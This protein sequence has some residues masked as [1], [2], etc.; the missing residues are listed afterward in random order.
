VKQSPPATIDTAIREVISRYPQVKLA[1][2]F[3]SSAKGTDTA[4]SDLDIAVLT[5]GPLASDLKIQI[6]GD[7][8][9]RFE[10]PV[11]LI[12]LRT[13][14]EPLLGQVL[15]GRRILGDDTTY[16][17]LITRHL[18]DAADLLPYRNRILAERRARW[19]DS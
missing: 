1:I 5:D 2:L 6:I 16:A 11:D 4:D 18:F 15:K 3:G 17:R 12:D 19:I 14:G 10:R 13:A 7:L 8:A 9:S